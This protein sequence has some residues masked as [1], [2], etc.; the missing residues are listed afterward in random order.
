MNFEDLKNKT[1]TTGNKSYI[2]IKYSPIAKGES[3]TKPFTDLFSCNFSNLHIET[4]KYKEM[5]NMIIS[6]TYIVVQITNVLMIFSAY[7]CM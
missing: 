4:A 3:L 6:Y 2:S 1:K 5:Q 7:A